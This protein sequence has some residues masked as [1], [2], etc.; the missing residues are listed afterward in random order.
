MTYPRETV[1][2]NRYHAD[3]NEDPAAPFRN[4]APA[5][6]T[7]PTMI[8]EPRLDDWEDPAVSIPP[9]REEV[10]ERQRARFGGL[11]VG[12]A[13]FGWLIATGVAAIVILVVA[14]TGVALGL[15]VAQ[16]PRALARDIPLDP[17]AVGWIS[18]GA[19]LALLLA[20][21]TCGGYVAGRMARFSGVAQGLAVWV[22]AL[23][24]ALVVVLISVV[25]GGR[26]DILG[27]LDVLPRLPVPDD[28]LTIATI[29]GAVV[30]AIVSLGGA[31]LG[32]LA[33][34]R[35]HRKVD[36]AGFEA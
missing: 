31:M 15:D 28:A 22:W 36:R 10:V 23:V 17:D 24:I 3:P 12:S 11:K 4:L 9:T 34:V 19:L 29:I 33:G 20:A 27:Y 2:P 14:A 6:T 25:L 16:S 8:I 18:V 21:F 13:F 35:Y 32:S 5:P 30:V 1:D 7:S 26:T